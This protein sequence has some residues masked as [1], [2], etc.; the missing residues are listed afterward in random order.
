[1]SA[2]LTPEEA[3]RIYAERSLAEGF[4]EMTE[5]AHAVAKAQ[6]QHIRN[7]VLGLRMLEHGVFVRGH[8]TGVVPKG[9]RERCDLLREILDWLDTEADAPPDGGEGS[10]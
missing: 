6:H 7:H 5:C 3:A 4:P 8:A 1:M 2:L 9:T 10:R